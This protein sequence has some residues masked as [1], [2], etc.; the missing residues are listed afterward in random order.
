MQ[1]KSI[2]RTCRRLL[3]GCFASF[4]TGLALAADYTPV[5]DACLAN[6]EPENWLM[7][8]GNYKGWSYSLLYQININNVK[9]RAGLEYIDRGRFRS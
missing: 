8:R 5:T 4:F 1:S 6:P 2:K 3:A 9:S 7:T